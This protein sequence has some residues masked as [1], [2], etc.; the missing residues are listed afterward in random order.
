M[1]VNGIKTPHQSQNIINLHATMKSLILTSLS[2]SIFYLGGACYP[3]DLPHRMLVGVNVVDTQIVC[4]AIS[5]AQGYEDNS[6]FNHS[7]R[8]WL[9]GSI[10]VNNNPAYTKVVDKEVHALGS[11]LH[12]IGFDP[13]LKHDEPLDPNH[14]QIGAKALRKFLINNT[15]GKLW[16]PSRVQL[17]VDTVALH[18]EDSDSTKAVEIRAVR[19]GQQIDILGPSGL[20][21]TAVYD[22]IVA[23]YPLGDM[24]DFKAQNSMHRDNPGGH[25]MPSHSKPSNDAPNSTGHGHTL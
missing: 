11:I 6:V 24:K 25:T 5:Y 10:I 23:A 8:S 21:T 12:D 1:E 18:L 15:E 20:V 16:E 2:F 17:L 3:S 9:F 19:D 14:P 13:K 4:D 7:M 22:S